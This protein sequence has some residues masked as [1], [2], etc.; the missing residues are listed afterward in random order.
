MDPAARVRSPEL[1]WAVDT[2][3][4]VI[5][6]QEK[7]IPLIPGHERLVWN[8]R[9]LIDGAR[10][11][12]LPT[13]ATE[14]YPQGLGKTVP[15]LAARLESL[16]DKLAFSCA[17]CSAFAEQLAAA[18]RPKVLLCGIETHVCVQQTALDLM[19]QGYRVYLAVDAVGSRHAIDHQTA[20]RRLELCGA[21]PLSVE[22]ALFEWCE[23]SGTP[24]F[25]TLSALVREA[26][27]EA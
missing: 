10:L 5:D 12:H 27:P 24:E 20:L 22:S 9:R 23:R 16:P 26:G 7:L 17:G 11:F 25:K 14:Q 1:L 19:S 21:T 18:G 6:V 4:V 3:L 15:E 8:I 2:A 13:L